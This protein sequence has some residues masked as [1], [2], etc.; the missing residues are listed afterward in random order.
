MKSKGM[1]TLV[2]KTTYEDQGEG[3][4]GEQMYH[5]DEFSMK[6]WF[7]KIARGVFN[8]HLG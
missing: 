6:N 7:W 1:L 3:P 2:I 5:Y 8:G 4:L